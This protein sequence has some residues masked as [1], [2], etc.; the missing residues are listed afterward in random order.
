VTGV[1]P[2]EVVASEEFARDRRAVQLDDRAL[3][4]ARRVVEDTL[5][6]FRD[7]R[8]SVDAGNGLVIREADGEWSSMTRLSTVDGLRIGIAA[9]LAAVD[10]LGAVEETP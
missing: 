7:R 2:A 4:V 10:A 5:V 3:S 6:D 8:I 1:T 9:Y